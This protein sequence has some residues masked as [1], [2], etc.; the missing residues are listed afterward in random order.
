[1]KL[2]E[3]KRLSI[4]ADTKYTGHVSQAPDPCNFLPEKSQIA[5]GEIKVH[6]SCN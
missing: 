1:M 3:V 2:G 5:N 6:G 4:A